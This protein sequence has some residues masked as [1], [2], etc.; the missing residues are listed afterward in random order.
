[1]TATL[2]KVKNNK[3]NK[4][5]VY[6]LPDFEGLHREFETDVKDLKKHGFDDCISS[7]KVIGQP[8]VLYE[9]ND[10]GGWL[11]P[12]EEGDY[13]NIEKKNNAFSSMRLITDDL[14]NP[15]ITLYV[16]ESYKGKNEPFTKETKLKYS[17]FDNKAS[18]HTVERGAWILYT[19][20]DR[21]GKRLLVRANE[22]MEDYRASGFNDTISHIRPL[23]AGRP[24]ITSKVRWNEQKEVNEICCL[25]DE[26]TV[27]NRSGSHQE[28]TRTCSREFE[29]SVMHEFKFS[30]TTTIEAGVAFEVKLIASMSTKIS[31]SFTVEK[32]KSE[33]VVEKE[34]VEITMP[35][36]FPANSKTTVRVMKKEY[37]IIVPVELTIWQNGKETIEDGEMRCE[38]G[39][40]IQAVITSEAIKEKE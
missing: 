39:N 7:L 13:K 33:T 19:D 29:S 17:N 35:S 34:K 15:Q 10:F 12:F 38:V 6:E 4:I 2:T 16:D 14:I 23:K 36:K 1:M 3:V 30:N 40:S 28:F 21:K 20:T 24:I 32:G 26:F 31:N 37:T 18:S 11:E 27:E 9:D 22:K 5:I 25:I 8:W